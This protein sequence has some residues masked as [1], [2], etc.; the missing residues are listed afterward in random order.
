[1]LDSPTRLRNFSLRRRHGLE[2]RFIL[3]EY[4]TIRAI[5]DRMR[6]DLNT[7]AQSL[8]Q[9]R[10]Q[11]FCFHCQESGSVGRVGVRTKQC[12]A[13]RTECAIGNNLYRPEV[14]TILKSADGWTFVEQTRG[15]WSWSINGFV[16]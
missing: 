1:M 14:K 11:F 15:V 6:L 9:H 7:L 3:V 4:E 2:C 16:D 5:A 8:D 12:R 10:S 13:T